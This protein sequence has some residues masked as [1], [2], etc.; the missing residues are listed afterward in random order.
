ML[1]LT[2]LRGQVRGPTDHPIAGAP[3]NVVGTTHGV[4]TD[5]SGE[6]TFFGLPNGTTIVEAVTVGYRPRRI[7][8]VVSDTTPYLVVRLERNAMLDS[9]KAVAGANDFE[10]PA[11]RITARELAQPSVVSGNMLEAL[12]LLRPQLFVTT[13][14][15]SMSTKAGSTR[16]K[17]VTGQV[18]ADSRLAAAFSVSVDEALPQAI[19]VLALIPA[20]TV[21]EVRY[22]RSVE[23][24]ARFGVTANGPVL[25]VYTIPAPVSP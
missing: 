11:D 25:I 3:V 12:E 5:E 19:D 6:F 1:P 2:L 13:P 16:G 17:V 14:P 18:N 22:L 20:R 10:R 21:K 7:P 8:V 15:T 4:V 9:M 23:A 24:Q